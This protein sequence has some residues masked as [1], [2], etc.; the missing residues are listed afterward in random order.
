M[1]QTKTTSSTNEPADN[2]SLSLFQKILLS[3]DGTVTD[4]IAL[5]T[6][7]PIRVTKL[8]QS[9]RTDVAPEALQCAGPTKLLSRKILLSGASRNYLYADSLFVFGRFSESIRQQLLQTDRP[10]GLMWKEERLETYR[11]IVEQ[12]VEPCA[13]I[14]RYFNLPESAPFVSR[15]YLIYQAG[16]PLGAITEKW[17][18]AFFREQD[19]AGL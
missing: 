11:E 2:P 8:D 14:T 4:L 9:I 3:T 1:Q 6:G 7:E 17:P 12:K 16:K 18:L 10:I 5:Y 19:S 13:E 15:T